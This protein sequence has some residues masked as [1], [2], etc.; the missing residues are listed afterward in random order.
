LWLLDHWSNEQLTTNSV[1]PKRPTIKPDE[2]QGPL[3]YFTTVSW[4]VS[5]PGRVAMR[6]ACIVLD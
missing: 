3:Y 6:L 4:P 5:G 1:V 2:F